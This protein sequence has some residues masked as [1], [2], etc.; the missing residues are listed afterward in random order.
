MSRFI[1]RAATVAMAV[2]LLMAS[3][4]TVSAAVWTDQSDYSPGSIVTISGDGMEP[5]EDVGVFVY[6]PDGTVAQY[7]EVV[8]DE[9][10]NFSDTYLLP[11]PEAAVQGTYGGVAT[12]LVSG[13]EFR[14][15]FTDH[16]P[17]PSSLTAT[18]VSSSAIDLEWVGEKPDGPP[19]AHGNHVERGEGTPA[20]WGD[21]A[22]EYA[23]STGT[24]SG[25]WTNTGNATL[26]S[27][28]SCA[29]IA[30]GSTGSFFV[31]NFGFS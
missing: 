28:N 11:P 8:A 4:G 31:K 30:N 27:D 10:G 5:G 9:A 26:A 12:G 20:E 13:S 19:H 16:A 25:S 1:H 14:T 17:N 23:N 2:A 7:N 24:S 18:A 21:D 6:F 22:E 3:V 15:T 29:T